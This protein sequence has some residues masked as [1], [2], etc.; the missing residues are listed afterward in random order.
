VAYFFT[1]EDVT[2]DEAY[3]LRTLHSALGRAA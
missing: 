3:V 1:Y 2:G